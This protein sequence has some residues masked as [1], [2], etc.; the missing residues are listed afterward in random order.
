MVISI[1]AIM[2]VGEIKYIALGQRIFSYLTGGLIYI[3]QR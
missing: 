1:A 2:G 3:K